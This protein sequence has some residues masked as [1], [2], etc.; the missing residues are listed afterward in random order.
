[1]FMKNPKIFRWLINVL[2]IVA[3][4]TLLI[5]LLGFEDIIDTQIL[6]IIKH[7]LILFI[8]FLF[9]I[10]VLWLLLHN[11]NEDVP[12][13]EQQPKEYCVITFYSI[14]NVNKDQY[15][16]AEN[17]IIISEEDD[18]LRIQSLGYFGESLPIYFKGH[19]S[20]LNIPA[21]DLVNDL[22]NKKGVSILYDCFTFN[23]KL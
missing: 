13:P 11:E 23:F 15:M 1:M 17:S 8:G 18:I 20:T 12:I 7:S 9:I 4:N 3:F 2:I 19:Q 22:A 6:S 16:H 21:I 5:H 14:V 10:I